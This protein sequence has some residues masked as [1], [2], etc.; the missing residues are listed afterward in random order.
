[1]I[2]VFQNLSQNEQE[3][4]F[5]SPLL[6]CILVA[7]AD[8]TIDD[9]EIDEAL[10]I[11]RKHHRVKSVLVEFFDI[12]SEDF[13]DKLKILIQSYPFERSA[14]NEIITAELANLNE[15]WTKLG[16]DFSKAYYELLKDLAKRIA[17][18]SGGM[19]G[20]KKIGP[21]EAHFLNLPM[22]ISP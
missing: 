20:M 13:E 21:E 14:R 9:D 1:M 17:S 4:V 15:L 18:S 19:W 16:A 3:L 8:G 6:V 22:L 2:S 7:G 5:K 12:M 11:A 10:S